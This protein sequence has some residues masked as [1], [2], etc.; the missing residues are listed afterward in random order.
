MSSSTRGWNSSG[1]SLIC[2]G[3]GRCQPARAVAAGSSWT[4]GG[5]LAE[6]G[7]SSALAAVRGW[8]RAVAGSRPC[9]ETQAAA[10]AHRPVG[11]PEGL[12]RVQA[13]HEPVHRPLDLVRVQGHWLVDAVH[14]HACPCPWLLE[15]P[16]QVL[17]GRGH[18]K[19]SCAGTPRVPHSVRAPSGSAAGQAG[20]CSAGAASSWGICPPA[21]AWKA[22]GLAT[23]R[24]TGPH[25]A[26]R[27]GS[28]AAGRAPPR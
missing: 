1:L 17:L 6:P 4:A 22:W 23:C 11:A 13:R 14:V 21:L 25:P 2:A 10:A 20:E 24:R 8:R 7:S 5:W 15:R 19:S 12:P 16:P 3:Q 9:S 27:S 26:S 28:S 18:A